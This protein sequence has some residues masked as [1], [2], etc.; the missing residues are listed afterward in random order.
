MKTPGPFLTEEEL[1]AEL[2][3]RFESYIFIAD[4]TTKSSNDKAFSYNSIWYKGSYAVILGL[5]T[6]AAIRVKMWVLEGHTVD[7]H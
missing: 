5:A 2:D 6:Y 4:Q 7:D 1:F 3:A